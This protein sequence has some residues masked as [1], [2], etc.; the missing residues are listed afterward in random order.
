[1]SRS[2]ARV[3][4]LGF[5]FWH[6]R[7]EFYHI[8]LGL[9]WSWFLRETWNEFNIGWILL[10]V[11]G[12]L[13]PDIDHFYYFFTYGKQA[14]YTRDIINFIKTHQWRNLVIYIE[15]GHKYNTSLSSHNYYMVLIMLGLSMLSF[16]IDW[17]FGV[18]LFGSIVIHY[19]FDVVD[20]FIQ[21]GVVNPNWK[22]WG[23]LKK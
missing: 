1:M 20:D 16:F 14:S 5:I 17:K 7:H 10:A 18:I 6:S 3:R 15:N 13:L 2:L 4:G 11:F 22:R 8:L 23:R 19:I 9:V 21:L 12:S